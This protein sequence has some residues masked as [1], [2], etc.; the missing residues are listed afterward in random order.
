MGMPRRT[1]CIVASFVALHGFAH[2][3]GASAAFGALDDPNGLDYLGGVWQ[4]TDPL[5]LRVFGVLWILLALAFIATGYV[6]WTQRSFWPQ[7]LLAVSAFSASLLVVAL[8][9]SVIGL[10]IDVLLA[11]FAIFNMRKKQ[12][13]EL[14]C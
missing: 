7:L 2:L 3:A 12:G 6:M 13:G 10:V 5:P 9:S 11:A 1:L 8:W 4:I 14:A